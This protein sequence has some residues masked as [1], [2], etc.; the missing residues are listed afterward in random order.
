MK[1]NKE[2]NEAMT[3]FMKQYQPAESIME[4]DEQLTTF[5]IMN[6]LVSHI[7]KKGVNLRSVYEKLQENGFQYEYVGNNFL[8]LLKIK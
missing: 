8:W 2:L 3:V 4:S 6:N 1:K 5:E 7:G